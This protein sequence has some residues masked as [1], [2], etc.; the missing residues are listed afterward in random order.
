MAY[1]IAVDTNLKTWT[2]WDNRYWPGIY[3]VDKKGVVRY[4]WYGELNYKDSPK[5]EPVMREKIEELLA[6]K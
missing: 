5:A 6:E 3:L 4:R 1:P 2:A